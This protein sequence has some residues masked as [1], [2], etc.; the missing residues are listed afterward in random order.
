MIPF[1][2]LQEA[3]QFPPILGRYLGL[4]VAVPAAIIGYIL[5]G[6]FGAPSWPKRTVLVVLCVSVWGLA[7]TLGVKALVILFALLDAVISIIPPQPP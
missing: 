7:T 3:G 5:A 4:I 2:P 1:W 6:V